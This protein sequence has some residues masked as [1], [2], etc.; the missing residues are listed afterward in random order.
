MF[1]NLASELKDMLTTK[2]INLS[3]FQSSDVLKK[4][5]ELECDEECLIA[6]RN[7]EMALAL[8]I[9]ADKA[10]DG[11]E[12][13]TPP[14]ALQLE[15]SGPV[16][17]PHVSMEK[18]IKSISNKWVSLAERDPIEIRK[19][20]FSVLMDIDSDEE[21]QLTGAASKEIDYFEMTD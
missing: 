14:V 2:S 10:K 7:K 15:K 18:K 6:K 13:E 11:S 20:P 9:D 4:K 5:T 19:S 21:K 8:Q 3:S 16:K 17:M 12:I 1:E